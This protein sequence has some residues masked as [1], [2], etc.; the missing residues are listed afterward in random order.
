M[1]NSDMKINPDDYE[2][3]TEITPLK[4]YLYTRKNK[5]D[6]GD[7]FLVFELPDGKKL[8]IDVESEYDPDNEIK[9]YD[10]IEEPK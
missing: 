3:T 8:T 2:F 7:E 1:N 5:L 4:T 9:L 6:F 10:F